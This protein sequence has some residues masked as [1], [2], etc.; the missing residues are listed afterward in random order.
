[1]LILAFTVV[2]FTLIEVPLVGYLLAPER[3]R[4][5]VEDF[6]RWFATHLR[7]IGEVIAIA[8]GIYL[9]VRGIANLVD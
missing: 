4:V 9:V 8:I 3:T 5:R 1:M 7:Q 2:Q 6:N